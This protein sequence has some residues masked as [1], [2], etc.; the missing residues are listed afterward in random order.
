[1]SEAL[2][3]MAREAVEQGV[4]DKVPLR[5]RTDDERRDGSEVEAVTKK[6]L[7]ARIEQLEQ[8]I[9]V[10][11]ARDAPLRTYPPTVV[12]YAE[13]FIPWHLRGPQCTGITSTGAQWSGNFGSLGAPTS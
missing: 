10:L 3:Q 13:P 8:R 5:R 4:Y 7:L 11:E 6:Q 12:P 2:D 1:M 9:A